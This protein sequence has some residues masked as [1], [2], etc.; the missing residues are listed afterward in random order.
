MELPAFELKLNWFSVLRENWLPLDSERV[1]ECVCVCV[2]RTKT[3]DF[4]FFTQFDVL[5][6]LKYTGVE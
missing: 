3:D 2:W 5:E 4:S 6:P 1:P